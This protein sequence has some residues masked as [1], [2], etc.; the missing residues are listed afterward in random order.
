MFLK[1]ESGLA[2]ASVT[3]RVMV[4]AGSG[5]AVIDVRRGIRGWA[6]REVC[7]VPEA[8]DARGVDAA[9]DAVRRSGRADRS[10]AVADAS[11]VHARPMAMTSRVFRDAR[12][13][14][15]SDLEELLPIDGAGAVIG[16]VDR[17]VPD[18][19]GD[20][21]GGGYL[22][23]IDGATKQRVD[24]VASDVLGK[25]C[26]RIVAPHQ[27]AVCL[28]DCVV[29]ELGVLGDQQDTLVR[30]GVLAE[31]RRDSV[32]ESPALTF[33]N[34]INDTLRPEVSRLA[35]CAAAL[36][37]FGSQATEP[38]VGAW[39]PGWK[40]ALPAV[41]AAGLCVAI[42][43]GAMA[44]RGQRY[45]NAIDRTLATQESLRQE[46]VS[47]ERLEAEASQL[48]E[49]L[50]AARLSGPGHAGSGLVGVFDAVRR[51]LPR[52][53][54]LESVT[55]DDAG[56]RLRGIALNAREVLGEL[57]ASE[58]FESAREVERPQPVGDG[59]Q[60]EVFDVRVAIRPV[61]AGAQR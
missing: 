57:E 13:G 40:R 12:G 4:F 14:L 20:G 43:I 34:R 42:L 50:G 19:E 23:A 30:G 55:V 10:M 54:F 16:Y 52:D 36:D 46:V 60:R 28:D 49:R 27:A 7:S 41:A 26:D 21:S 8:S 44:L 22:L 38:L 31:L 5:F 17:D 53:A 33:P 25:H 3:T 56:V 29:R 6:T 45:A 15:R 1:Q 37:R 51:A 61:P 47:V 2:I 9:R 39:T 32:G 58:E 11:S 18:A 59:S 35:I 24:R 48:R